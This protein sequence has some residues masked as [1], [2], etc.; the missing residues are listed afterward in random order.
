MDTS[1][2]GPEQHANRWRSYLNDCGT[3]L[4]FEA[5]GLR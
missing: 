2:Q 4:D 3:L 5:V 1:V